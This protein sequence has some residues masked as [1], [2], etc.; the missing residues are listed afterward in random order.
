M[1][2]L[3]SVYL[4]VCLSVCRISQKVIEGFEPNFVKLEEAVYITHAGH[5]II[6]DL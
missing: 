3:W 1:V 6:D 5:S 4:S 2:I